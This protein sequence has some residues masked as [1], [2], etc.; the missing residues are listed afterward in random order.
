[1]SAVDILIESDTFNTEVQDWSQEN[2]ALFSFNL[3]LS[4]ASYSQ[5]RA[6]MVHSLTHISL[7]WQPNPAQM[8]PPDA[9]HAR[10]HNGN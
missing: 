6:L 5:R 8:S 3:C 1:M 9:K 10:I 2:Q 4:T 7:S